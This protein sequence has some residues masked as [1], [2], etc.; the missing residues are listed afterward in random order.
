MLKNIM[1]K[2]EQVKDLVHKYADVFSSPEKE[3]GAMSL[4]EFQVKLQP[5]AQPVKQK[6]QPLNPQQKEDLKKQLDL[7]ERENVFEE[8]ESPWSS[9][10]V[11][12]LKKDGLIRSAIDHRQLNRVTVANAYPLPHIQ[13]NL[14]CRYSALGRGLSLQY[15]T[16]RNKE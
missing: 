8:T 14:D 5:R 3:I 12:A 16:S 6:V 11:P 15:Y 2:L 7:W 9:A 4:I 13:D 10:L 1:G